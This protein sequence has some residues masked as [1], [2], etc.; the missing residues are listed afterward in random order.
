MCAAVLLDKKDDGER[1]KVCLPMKSELIDLAEDDR[2][3]GIA[4]V[5][6]RM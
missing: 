5:R 2:W 1:H 3:R 6:A 4:I